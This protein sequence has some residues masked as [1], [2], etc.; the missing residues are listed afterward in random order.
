MKMESVKLIVLL[1][2]YV[3]THS[4]T[5]EQ[6]V[7]QHD[8]PLA[9]VDRPKS[10]GQLPTRVASTTRTADGRL[11]VLGEEP[12]P[13]ARQP[14]PS[15]SFTT[16]R[17]LNKALGHVSRLANRCPPPT[18]A[19]PIF[20]SSLAKKLLARTTHSLHNLSIGLPWE[21]VNLQEELTACGTCTNNC[22]KIK[23]A[24]EVGCEQGRCKI[25]ESCLKQ[26]IIY[27]S[28]GIQ[29]SQTK[30]ERRTYYILILSN[31]ASCS[32]KG[33]RDMEA[34]LDM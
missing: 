18:S 5:D 14:V 2:G 20:S 21:C 12:A 29:L 8:Q 6:V 27:V 28:G 33:G 10:R 9:Q 24:K 31:D 7:V 25:C 16:V 19:C 17:D 26:T 30:L 15:G 4:H 11:V 23:H 34:R 32:N 13:P 1:S 3:F 22:M